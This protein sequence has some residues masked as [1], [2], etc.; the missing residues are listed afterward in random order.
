ML[1]MGTI[2][3]NANNNTDPKKIIGNDDNKSYIN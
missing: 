3:A 2:N 1:K